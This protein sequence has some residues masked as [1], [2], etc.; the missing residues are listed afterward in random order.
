[1]QLL[2][3]YDWMKAYHAHSAMSYVC[4]VWVMC[5]ACYEHIS[6]N[7]QHVFCHVPLLHMMIK[8]NVGELWVLESESGE[9]SLWRVGHLP[10]IYLLSFQGT[11]PTSSTLTSLIM[12]LI[13]QSLC[14][15]QTIHI[16]GDIC[17][18]YRHSIG[19]SLCDNY[20]DWYRTLIMALIKIQ[21]TPLHEKDDDDAQDSQLVSHQFK[22][23]SIGS[24]RNGMNALLAHN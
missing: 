19:S 5:W 11:Q 16:Y 20:Y 22:A 14:V 3:C 17:L 21:S 13:I 23:Q 10:L 4:Y 7:T 12:R 9:E 15:I 24:Q 2:G 18:L 6:H 1:M 8:P